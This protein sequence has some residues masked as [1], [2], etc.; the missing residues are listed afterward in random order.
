MDLSA[1][2]LDAIRANVA[3][4]KTASREMGG[5]AVRVV[6]FTSLEDRL[7]LAMKR[8]G[9]KREVIADLFGVSVNAVRCRFLELKKAPPQGRGSLHRE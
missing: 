3:R 7:L 1:I 2:Q 5:D 4:R 6:P 9:I 8:R